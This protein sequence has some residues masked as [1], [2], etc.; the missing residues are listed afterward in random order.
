MNLFEREY[1]TPELLKAVDIKRS[2]FQQWLDYGYVDPSV[3]NASS[4]GDRHLFSLK[5]IYTVA[6]FKSLI[7]YGFSRKLT[8]S[9]IDLIRVSIDKD[10]VISMP[11]DIDITVKYDSVI[12]DINKRIKELL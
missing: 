3:K 8:G 1:T 6:V 2:R 10:C 9:M 7:E 4:Q 12:A 11:G 5:D